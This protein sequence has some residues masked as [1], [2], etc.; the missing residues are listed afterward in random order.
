[1]GACGGIGGIFFV[2]GDGVVVTPFLLWVIKRVSCTY[3]DDEAFAGLE[4]LRRIACWVYGYRDGY[5]E[6]DCVNISKIDAE[7][8]WADEI[9]LSIRGGDSGVKVHSVLTEDGRGIL[10]EANKLYG[11]QCT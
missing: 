8:G 6:W 2:V 5:G 7:D 9:V 10:Q 1:M 4:I 11:D 3:E